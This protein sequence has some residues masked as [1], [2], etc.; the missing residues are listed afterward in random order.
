MKL[1]DLYP[2]GYNASQLLDEARLNTLNRTDEFDDWLH[3][4]KDLNARA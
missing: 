1:A 2:I 4:L 3:S